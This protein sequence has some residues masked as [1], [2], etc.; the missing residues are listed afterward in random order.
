MNTMEFPTVD[1]SDSYRMAP[2]ERE[3]MDDLAVPRVSH[4]PPH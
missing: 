1:W 3:V 4:A 2:E